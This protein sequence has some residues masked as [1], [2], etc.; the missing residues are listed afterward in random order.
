ME[1]G[2]RAKARARVRARAR[3]RVRKGYDPNLERPNRGPDELELAPRESVHRR[4]DLRHL[5]G[6]RSRGC[7]CVGWGGAMVARSRGGDRR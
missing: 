6:G 7:V 1:S 4:V 5:W 2:V 3:A